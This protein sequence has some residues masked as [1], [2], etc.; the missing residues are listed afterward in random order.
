[1]PPAIERAAILGTGVGLL[2]GSLAMWH[3]DPTSAGA[4]IFSGLLILLFV[5][6][7]ARRAP[8]GAA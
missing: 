3:T 8:R 2:L 6:V 5:L 4:G 7:A 1:M